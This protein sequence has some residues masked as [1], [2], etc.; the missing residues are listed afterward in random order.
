MRAAPD[1][2]SSSVWQMLI[3][4]SSRLHPQN[5]YVSSGPFQFEPSFFELQRIARLELANQ[6]RASTGAAALASKAR[7]GDAKLEAA[8]ARQN[9]SAPS[10]SSSSSASFSSSSSAVPRMPG[11]SKS[12][13]SSS[14]TPETQ[15]CGRL[16][17]VWALQFLVRSSWLSDASKQ[18]VLR[19]FRIILLASRSMIPV[20]PPL[21]VPA[22]HLACMRRSGSVT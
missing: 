17:G 6:R 1:S 13:T 5:E 11:D 10:S 16:A 15:A 3:Q 22:S 21:P 19:L 20:H 9:G 12:E 2:F 7:S 14:S 4:S 8:A 18:L